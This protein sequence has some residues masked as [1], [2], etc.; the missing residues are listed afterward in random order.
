MDRLIHSGLADKV[1]REHLFAS[2]H[3]AV[4]W[5]LSEMDMEAVSIHESMHPS[6]DSSNPAYDV[7][8]V[9]SSLPITSWSGDKPDIARRHSRQGRNQSLLDGS[10]E[11]TKTPTHISATINLDTDGIS[12]TTR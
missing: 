9:L 10:N 11:T 7:E 4:N 6:D 8:A 1:G 12:S 5:C 2:E 3:D